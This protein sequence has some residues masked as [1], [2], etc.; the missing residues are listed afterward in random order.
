[1][2]VICFKNVLQHGSIEHFLPWLPVSS[3]LVLV[4]HY[5]VYNEFLFV[6]IICF[7]HRSGMSVTDHAA[8]MELC[9]KIHPLGRPG[10]ADEVAKVIA[11][12]A[13]DDA[14]FIT[15]QTLAVDGGR[16]VHNG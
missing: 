7:Y 6:L 16:S 11:F 15:G 9:K 4:G 2:R 13:S 1:M 12:L 14:S 10:K 5:Q 3:R 8:H